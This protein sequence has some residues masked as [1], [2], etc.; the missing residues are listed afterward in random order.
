MANRG[1][2]MILPNSEFDQEFEFQPRSDVKNP[3]AKCG[4][5]WFYHIPKTGGSTVNKWLADHAF[6]MT[7]KGWRQRENMTICDLWDGDDELAWDWKPRFENITKKIERLETDKDHWIIVNHHNYG[8]GLWNFRK[9]LDLTRESVEG[10]ECKFILATMLREP[11]SHFLSFSFFAHIPHATFSKTISKHVWD[12][13]QFKYLLFN[14]RTHKRL[15]LFYQDMAWTVLQMFDIIGFTDR[16]NDFVLDFEEK[17]G[18]VHRDVNITRKTNEENKYPISD[19]EI[20]E[21]LAG[22]DQ[23]LY[24]FHRLRFILDRRRNDKLP[25]FHSILDHG[26]DQF[27]FS[28]C[29]TSNWMNCG[30]P[31]RKTKE[32]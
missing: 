7:D 22:L 21:I 25:E 11:L 32:R 17:T 1:P 29:G 20:Q 18:W 27:D 10:M 19:H 31:P 26:S 6:Q 23:E 4:V 16:F 14:F 12:F 28:D 3:N 13:S 8:P 15:K 24:F 9:T 5:V 30:L 2:L